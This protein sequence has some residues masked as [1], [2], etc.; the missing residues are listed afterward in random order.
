MPAGTLRL[1]PLVAFLA[2]FRGLARVFDPGLRGLVIGPLIINILVVIGLATAAGVGFEALL[3]AW[4]PGGWDWLAWLLWPLF[5]LALLVAFGVSAVALAAIIAS[6]FSGPL[7][8]R[9]ARGLGHEPRQPARS[10]LGEMGHATVTALRKAGYY[11]LLFIPV[12]LITVIP[13]LN[14]LAPIA[15]FTFGSWVLAVEFLEAPLANDGLAFAEVRKTVRAHRLETLS[16]GAGT[17]LLAMVP[18]VN[19]LLVPAAVIGATHLRVRLPRA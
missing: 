7:A 8:Y 12:L 11:G 1:T 18:L 14:L 4:L 17:T 10:F 19:L 9:T 3:A 16:F 2:P 5:A 13:G 15:W 6:P